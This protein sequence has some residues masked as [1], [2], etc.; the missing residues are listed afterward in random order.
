[1]PTTK[2]PRE[3]VIHT[4]LKREETKKKENYFKPKWSEGQN[5]NPNQLKTK[6]GTKRKGAQLCIFA[7]LTSTVSI[8]HLR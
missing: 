4:A 1:M 7:L 2:R 6:E 3:T 5:K 8:Q